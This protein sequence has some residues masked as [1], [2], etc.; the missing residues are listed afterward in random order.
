M[1][2]SFVSL[3]FVWMKRHSHP[4]NII[5]LGLFTVFEAWLVGTI[6]GMYES[7]IVR[8]HSVATQAD[9]QGDSGTLHHSWSLY[10]PHALYFPDKG[11]CALPETA[12]HQFDF[13]SMAPF[14]FAG[15]MGILTTSLVQ[16]FLPFS[17]GVDLFVA[18]FSCLIFSGYILYDVS[19]SVHF[20]LAI[21]WLC[22]TTRG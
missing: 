16:I 9:N 12:N 6:V 22:G 14:L 3:F 20:S 21:H 13:S 15:L 5:L 1:I 8:H 17:K 2:G 10:R 4:A 18:G 7:R 11:T 19:D